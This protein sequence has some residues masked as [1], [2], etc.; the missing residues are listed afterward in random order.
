MNKLNNYVDDVIREYLNEMAMPS[1]THISSFWYHGTSGKHIDKIIKDKALK[2]SEAVTKRS[3]GMMT[4]VFDKVYLTAEINEAIGYA[5]FRSPAD[6]PAYLV[7]V[8]GKALK[9]IQPD[10]DSIADLLQTEDT[11]KGFEWLV[12]LAKYTDPK[13]YDKFLRMRDYA[14]S[15]SLAKKIVNKLSDARKIELINKGMKIAHSGAIEISQVWELPPVVD[16]RNVK[17]TINGDTYQEL[18]KRIY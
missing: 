13:L 6:T 12:S 4:P 3:R 9:D 18:G 17:G 5:Y 7:I 1:S 8:D 15:V 10:E 11:I 14:Y 2:P 16:K